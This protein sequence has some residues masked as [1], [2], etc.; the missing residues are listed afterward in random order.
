MS[1]EWKSEGVMDDESGDLTLKLGA[2][3][4]VITL[5]LILTIKPDFYPN[6]NHNPNPTYSNK[7]TEPYQTVPS[8]G[9]TLIMGVILIIMYRYIFCNKCFAKTEV[10]R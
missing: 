7:C 4:I 10:T 5:T 3:R 8:N 6:P 9:V 1:W 2:I